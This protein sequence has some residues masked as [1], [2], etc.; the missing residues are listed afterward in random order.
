MRLVERSR[1]L[2]SLARLQYTETF[3]TMTIF[4]SC[5][6]GPTALSILVNSRTLRTR[7]Q[8]GYHGETAMRRDIRYGNGLTTL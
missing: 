8:V 4:R 5:K 1:K 6:H 7:L 2:A 3:A